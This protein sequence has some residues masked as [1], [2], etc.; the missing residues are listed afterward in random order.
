MNES[1][2]IVYDMLCWWVKIFGFVY[3]DSVVVPCLFSEGD[4][5]IA[6]TIS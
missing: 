3:M 2:E 4:N 6:G 1:E 5:G